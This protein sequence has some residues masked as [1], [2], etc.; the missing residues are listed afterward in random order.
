MKIRI[1]VL[2]SIVVFTSFGIFLSYINY[3]APRFMVQKILDQSIDGNRNYNQLNVPISDE[4]KESLSEYFS[5]PKLTED[6]NYDLKSDY[7]DEKQL[8]IIVFL[9]KFNY[10]DQNDLISITHGGLVFK[11][12]RLSITKWKIDKITFTDLQV[13]L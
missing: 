10:N 12:K 13:N 3:Y 11:M 2:T 8:F 1:F 9:E 5:N 6:L 7:N 4:M